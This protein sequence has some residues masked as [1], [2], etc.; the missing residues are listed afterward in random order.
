[1][2]KPTRPLPNQTWQTLAN[3]LTTPVKQT[4]G[5]CA[6][7]ARKQ[8]GIGTVVHADGTHTVHFGL[9][10]NG[11]WRHTLRGVGAEIRLFITTGEQNVPNSSHHAMNAAHGTE[12]RTSF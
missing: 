5:A 1:M 4:I 12:S 3:R 6:M 11:Q 8:K 9:V 2:P 10:R 7:T